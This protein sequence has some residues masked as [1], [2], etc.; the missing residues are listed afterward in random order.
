[1]P[2]VHVDVVIQVDLIAA[3]AVVGHLQLRVIDIGGAVHGDLHPGVGRV[4]PAHGAAVDP[5]VVAQPSGQIP[6][7]GGV[8]V[9]VAVA[10]LEHV[11]SVGLHPAGGAELVGGPA[12]IGEG[13]PGVDVQ[14]PELLLPGHGVVGVG[15]DD[16][17]EALVQLVAAGGEMSLAVEGEAPHAGVHR[18]APGTG[19]VVVEPAVNEVEAG[20]QADVRLGV[21]G[22]D[23]AGGSGGVAVGHRG[24]H[25]LGVGPAAGGH[26]QVQPGGIGLG[27]I[28]YVGG[29]AQGPVEDGHR[30]RPGD[31]LIGT[32]GAVAE[33]L[34]P[35]PGSGREDIG[36][37]GAGGGYIGEL[38]RVGP[39]G[40]ELGHT[41]DE[42][43]P[44]EVLIGAK[45]AHPR[46][47]D[48][49]RAHDAGGLGVPCAGGHVGV[50]NG[51]GHRLLQQPQEDLRRLRPGQVV[52]GAEQAAA[53]GEIGNMAVGDEGAAGRIFRRDALAAGVLRLG[54][55]GLL[56]LLAVIPVLGH[57]V[58]GG[59]IGD[60]AGGRAVVRRGPGQGGQQDQNRQQQGAKSFP[61]GFLP[62]CR[63]RAV[64][65]GVELKSPS[66]G[67]THGPGRCR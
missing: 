41:A 16:L 60:P 2:A 19:I 22:P 53:A 29:A 31:E 63:A 47:H 25:H 34:H 3:P 55:L 17:V 1:M 62:P 28:A 5:G 56:I 35:A 58:G 18:E 43:P 59:A 40:E 12:Q 13:V 23:L 52:L 64:R 44:G 8:A 46:P 50:V 6:E 27:Q 9:A 42:L 4:V 10:G 15:Q 33:A 21:A 66:P 49:Q 37:V 67:P 20:G 11:Q 32:E 57:V 61:H 65:R 48:P 24:L 30:L 14:G 54:R 51:D 36:G 45:G 38:D 39:G 7:H 26:I